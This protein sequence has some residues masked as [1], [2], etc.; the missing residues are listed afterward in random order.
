[1]KLTSC[2]AFFLSALL[3]VCIPTITYLGLV[4]AVSILS[5]STSQAVIQWVDVIMAA[6]GWAAFVFFII[7]IIYRK[8]S[9]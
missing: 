4:P 9:T 3:G 8:S 5:A 6:L 1:M 2:T 7:G